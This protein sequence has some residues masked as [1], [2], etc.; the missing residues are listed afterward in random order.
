MG[1]YGGV[2]CE[3]RALV[4]V[5]QE[6]PLGSCVLCSYEENVCSQEFNLWC[7]IQKMCPTCSE[8]EILMICRRE[9]KGDIRV[10]FLQMHAQ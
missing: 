4:S 2:A 1:L 8:G 3:S 9:C 7:L 5:M 6:V 10:S